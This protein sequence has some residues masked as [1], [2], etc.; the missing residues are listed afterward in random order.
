MRKLFYKMTYSDFG[1]EAIG[2]RDHLNVFPLALHETY[3]PQMDFAILSLHPKNH[4]L[5][6]RVGIWALV[7]FEVMTDPVQGAGKSLGGNRASAGNQRLRDHRPG[8]RV[9]L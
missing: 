1:S 2:C 5:I 3:V 4:L 7:F 6:Q 8:P 9:S